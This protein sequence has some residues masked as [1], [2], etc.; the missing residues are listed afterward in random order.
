MGRIIIIIM[1]LLF[2]TLCWAQCNYQFNQNQINVNYNGA[3]IEIPFTINAQRPGQGQS[4]PPGIC[5]EIAFFF[6]TGN[7]NSYNRKVFQGS[8]SM[9]YTLEKI[10]PSGTLKAFGDHSGSNEFL[11]SSIDYNQSINLQ[12][13]FKIPVQGGLPNKGLYQDVVNVTAYGYNNDNANQQGMTKQLVINVQ[14]QDFMELSIVPVGAAHDGSSTSAILN[15][16]QL[17]QNQELAADLIVRANSGYRVK[18]GSQNNGSFKHA[19][20]NTTIPYQFFFAGN[21]INLNGTNGNPTNAVYNSNSTPASGNRYNMKVRVGALASNQANGDY[22]DII[23]VTI[24]S[25]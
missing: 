12:G 11:S 18:V 2:S 6:G 15:F 4:K 3:A 21:T 20:L 19:T 10:N 7:A 16:G 5:N 24:S 22:T 1:S 9:S 8:S 13:V 14:V 17:A 25:P 23:T